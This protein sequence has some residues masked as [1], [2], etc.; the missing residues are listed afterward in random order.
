[1]FHTKGLGS[2]F[3][4]FLTVP[5]ACFNHK[6]SKAVARMCSVKKVFL[7]ILENSQK[8]TC[9]TVS[10]LRRLQAEAE[11]Q[12]CNFNKKE[13]LPQVLLCEFWRTFKKTFF[14][15]T[16][17]LSLFFILYVIVTMLFFI[18]SYND[19]LQYFFISITLIVCITLVNSYFRAM[20]FCHAKYII[21]WISVLKL[22]EC[23]WTRC[24]EQLV[25]LT[26]NISD[27]S[28]YC[29]PWTSKC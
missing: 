27:T 19:L 28:F 23:Q 2:F 12:A 13:T 29:W 8:R 24:S 22:F 18:I 21:K 11:A 16:H 14:Y 15:R 17:P 9:T 3:H 25:L 26:L 7:E 20:C 1:M 10:F 6:F 4:G 5:W